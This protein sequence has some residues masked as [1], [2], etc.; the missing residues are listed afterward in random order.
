MHCPTA[1]AWGSSPQAGVGAWVG[2]LA[3]GEKAKGWRG[4]GVMA[5]A[6]IFQPQRSRFSSAG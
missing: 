6:N 5:A 2:G 1:P 3:E 4:D